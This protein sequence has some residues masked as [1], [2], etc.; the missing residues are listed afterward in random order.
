MTYNISP[1]KDGPGL[2]KDTIFTRNR[3]FLLT[4]NEA[5]M[6]GTSYVLEAGDPGNPGKLIDMGNIKAS[7]LP[8]V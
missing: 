4:N 1:S 5:A 3:K 2:N 8:S 6:R 7:Q